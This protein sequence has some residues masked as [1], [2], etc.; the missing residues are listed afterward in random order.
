MAKFY[1]GQGSVEKTQGLVSLGK[2][3]LLRLG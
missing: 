1:D 3:S 2:A